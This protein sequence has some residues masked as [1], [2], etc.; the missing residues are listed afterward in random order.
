MFE[1]AQSIYAT[2]KDKVTV[3]LRA[4]PA[5]AV[6]LL[7]VLGAIAAVLIVREA[8]DMTPAALLLFILTSPVFLQS[9]A[10]S[11]PQLY[12]HTAFR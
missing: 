2:T 7:I 10:V 11:R 12:R 8:G 9:S 1:S 3:S 5:A 4:S 6:T